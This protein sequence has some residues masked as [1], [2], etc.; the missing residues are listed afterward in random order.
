MVFTPADQ[1]LKSRRNSFISSHERLQKN[2]HS[3][4]TKNKK[5]YQIDFNKL[6]AQ[7][8]IEI[9]LA[10]QEG[11]TFDDWDLI[12]IWESEGKLKGEILQ[13]VKQHFNYP[14]DRQ[15]DID[16]P[17]EIDNSNEDV[18]FS[19]F[20]TLELLPMKSETEEIPTPIVNP[21]TGNPDID[22]PDFD[23]DSSEVDYPDYMTDEERREFTQRSKLCREDYSK[24]LQVYPED[25]PSN[26]SDSPQES[27]I[28]ANI[29]LEDFIPLR[30]VRD[31]PKDW[32]YT[33]KDNLILVK[34][35]Y[36]YLLKQDKGKL[37]F[38]RQL[39]T[40][41]SSL[42]KLDFFESIVFQLK[43]DIA[44]DT[45]LDKVVY[46]MELLKVNRQEFDDYVHYEFDFEE[47]IDTDDEELLHD[48]EVKVNEE[49]VIGRLFDLYSQDSQ[50]KAFV[51]PANKHLEEYKKRLEKDYR[52]IPNKQYK[53]LSLFGDNDW[54]GNND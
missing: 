38:L 30:S 17:E 4:F 8:E 28:S 49:K 40:D 5:K 48:M 7:F 20:G 32:K 24:Y 19:Y 25:D 41:N 14:V 36:L 13:K 2:R 50:D 11:I 51:I 39:D 29:K 34:N 43:K 53:Q 22:D 31:F 47:L 15:N 52:Y 35:T 9:E 23:R 54:G 6:T 37:I 16:Y 42:E 27:P 3:C 12:D 18:N 21:E 33:R 46:Y 26:I 44:K 10:A 45:F 1:W